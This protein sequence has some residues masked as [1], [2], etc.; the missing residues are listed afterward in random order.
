M[1]VIQNALINVNDDKLNSWTTPN[2]GCG[3]DCG[4]CQCKRFG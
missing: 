3:R 4:D 1:I 2:G